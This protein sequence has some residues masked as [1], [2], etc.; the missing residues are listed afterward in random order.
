MPGTYVADVCSSVQNQVY[1][2]SFTDRHVYISWSQNESASF[3]LP[4]YSG[5][6]GLNDAT[7]T[8]TYTGT[9]DGQY[10]V[11]I[12]SVAPDTQTFTSAVGG[13]NDAYF[14]TSAYTGTGTNTYKVSIVADFAFTFT[15]TPTI[16]PSPG[17]ILVGSVSNAIGRVQFLDSGGQDPVLVMLSDSGFEVGDTI[18]GTQGT[19]GTV[20]SAVGGAWVQTFKNGIAFVPSGFSSFVAYQFLVG[21]QLLTDGITLIVGTTNTGDLWVTQ[22]VGDYYELVKGKN[23]TFSWSFNGAPQGSNIRQPSYL[24]ELA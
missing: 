8:G 11:T 6:S 15:G 5:S 23:D 17:D 24:T 2:L 20:A 1:Y 10:Q 19:Y 4:V 16:T 9:V 22:N 13:V 7:F 14:G 12:D 18:T 21:T 3:S